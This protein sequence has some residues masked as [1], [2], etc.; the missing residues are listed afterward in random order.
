MNSYYDEQEDCDEMSGYRRAQRQA[1]I[2]HLNHKHHAFDWG[3]II[4]FA[5]IMGLLMLIVWLS[6]CS[7]YK[8][9][10]HIIDTRYNIV[11]IDSCE[12]I[13]IKSNG[14]LLHKANC[15]NHDLRNK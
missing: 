4:R 12:Y 11:V 5:A 1:A 15:K 13:E 3:N 10:T 14:H 9:E 8:A 7:E 6:G 2:K